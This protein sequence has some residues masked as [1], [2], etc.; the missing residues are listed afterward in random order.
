MYNDN[1]LLNGLCDVLL[2]LEKL[3]QGR[4]RNGAGPHTTP[5][6]LHMR[7][8]ANRSLTRSSTFAGYDE[9]CCHVF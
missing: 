1:H 3:T 9:Q 4:S 6:A 8:F 5:H 2:F 7:S